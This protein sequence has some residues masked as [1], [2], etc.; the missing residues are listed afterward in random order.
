MRIAIIGAGLGGL[1]A[2]IQLKQAGYTDIAVFEKEA[3][4]G[5]TWRDNRY[6]GCACDVPVALYQL[7]FAPSPNWSHIFPRAPEIGQYTEDLCD[8]F[9]LRPHLR[10][11]EEAVSAVWD[12]TKAAWTLTTRAGATYEA[13]VIVPALGQLNRPQ[14]PDIPGR[15]SFKGKAMHSARWDESVDLR[16]K[17]VACIGSAASAVQ[18]IPEVAKEAGHLTVFQRSPNWC[19]PRNDAA[20]TPEDK[21]LLMTDLEGA[22]KLGALN[23]EIIFERA[24]RFFW[25]AFEWTPAGRAALTRT[26]LDHLH[27][28]VADPELRAKLTPD[29]PIG[30]KRV[31]FVD[32]YYP[33]LQQPNVSLV[34]ERIERITETGVVTT[35][36]AAHDVD[37]I[38][39]A[40]GFET[41][42][43][44]WSLDVVGRGGAHLN[45]AWK[46]GPESYLGILSAGFPNM[47]MLYGPN[48]NLGHNSITFMIER[49]VAY[50]LGALAAL[51]QRNARSV[52]VK[53]EAQARFNAALQERLAKTVWA[54]PHCSSWYKNA[55]GRIT[56]NW[57]SHCRDYAKATAEL[58]LEDLALA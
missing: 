48:T 20:I 46:D 1:C 54:D 56:Q 6:P 50:M 10:L 51:K 31:L 28:Q 47:F 29:Y 18:L 37:V 40:T 24:D 57:G 17:R 25:Q 8:W 26:A 5:G 35:D 16:G 43:W 2:A 58:A 9:Q 23:R 55:A 11:N 42:G 4:V 38:I 15:D 3:S 13:D 19:I 12:E 45:E 41:T 21:A 49:Q 34:T 36:V 52:D 39:Y 7:S 44:H 30:C 33:A 53:P 32:D 27:A 22:M 14:W